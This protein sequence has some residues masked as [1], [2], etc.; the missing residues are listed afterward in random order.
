MITKD[1]QLT[2]RRCPPETGAS[3][4]SDPSSLNGPVPGS[5]YAGTYMQ[6]AT[7]DLATAETAMGGAIWTRS[8]VP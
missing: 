7:G 3:F 1:I 6:F 8:L 2:M 5:S 4:F